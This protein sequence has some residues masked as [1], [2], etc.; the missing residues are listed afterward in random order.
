MEYGFEA[1]PARNSGKILRHL[2][3]KHACVRPDH[4][5]V[6]TQK[7]NAEDARKAGTRG[8]LSPESRAEIRELIVAGWVQRKIAARYGVSPSII[9]RIK[10]DPDY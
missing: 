3:G 9:T 10:Q 5:V 2:C 6:G 4:L 1:L 8:K 7:E